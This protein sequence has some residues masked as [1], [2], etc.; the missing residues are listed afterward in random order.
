[1]DK[2]WLSIEAKADKKAIIK[3]HGTIGGGFFE[4]GVT[5]EQ[6]EADLEEI[7]NLKANIIDVDLASLGGSVKHGQRI[8]DLLRGNSA[9]VHINITGWTASMGAIIS[10]AA[11]KGKLRISENAQLLFHEARGISM[12]TASQL[13]A[14]ARFMRN[15]NA[16]FATIISRRSGMTE[17]K[18]KKLLAENN[19]E[20]IFK[21]PKE[22]KAEGLVD[23]IYKPESNK[24][25]ASITKEELNKYKI[26]AIIKNQKPN[27]MEF[28][29]KAVKDYVLDL[30]NTGL[31][32]LGD[33]DKTSENLEKLVNEGVEMAIEG[34]QPKIN[35]EIESL[36]AKISELEESNKTLKANASNP[37]GADAPLN[38]DNPKMTE[39]R[40]AMEEFKSQLSDSAVDL[41]A[42]KANKED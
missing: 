2:N 11:D 26:N 35:E 39:A 18:A 23:T 9:E 17:A 24:M 34:L 27:S 31:K 12:G 21:L 25:A 36:N 3:I 15:I 33:D 28:N 10:Q 4:E 42:S 5:D 29:V 41:M 8:Y 6:V 37:V 7:K 40:I 16:Q 22:A 19:S 30:V 32:A 38:G 1:M 13:E 20:G 14:D